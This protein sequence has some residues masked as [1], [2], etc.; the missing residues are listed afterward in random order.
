MQT[1]AENESELL[2]K[3]LIVEYDELLNSKTQDGLAMSPVFNILPSK[4]DYPDYYVLIKNPISFNTLKKRLTQYTDVQQFINDA[5]QIP[6]NAKMYNAK[7]S[8]I[9][10]YAV[11]L[12]NYITSSILI[13]L[14]QFYS[15]IEY[16]YLGALPDELSKQ[17]YA[18]PSTGQEMSMTDEN[19]VQKSLTPTPTQIPTPANNVNI[20]PQNMSQ[21]NNIKLNTPIVQQRIQETTNVNINGTSSPKTVTYQRTLPI[22]DNSSYSSL[23]PSQSSTP[24]PLYSRQSQPP[25]QNSQKQRTHV[26]RGRP[27][28][29]DLPYVQRIKNIL[30]MFRKEVDHAGEPLTL[31]FEKLPDKVKSPE[32][33]QLITNPISLDDIRKKVKT[34]KY[35]NFQTFQEEMKLMLSNYKIANSND[36]Q[37]AKRHI[38]L[39]KN[40]GRMVQFELSKPDEEYMPE[41]ELRYPLEEITVRGKNYYIGDWVMLDNPNDSS[42]PTVGQIFKLWS[43]PDGRKWLNACWYIRPEQTVHRVDR[44]FYKNEVVKTGQYRDHLVDEV[45][46]KCYVVHFTRFQR[47]DPAIKIDGP[48]FVCEFRYNENDKAFNKIR[49]WKA[50]LP[51]EIRGH[52]E[53]T[54][55]VNGRK[56]FKYPSPIKHMLPANAMPN[57]LTPQPTE[58]AING[59]PLIGAVYLRP[60]LLKDDLG[61]YSTSDDCPR[62]IIRPGDPQEDGKIDFEMGTITTNSTTTSNLPKTSHSNIKLSNL[63]QN[64]MINGMPAVQNTQ[65]PLI[66]NG[67]KNMM[68]RTSIPIKKIP[69]NNQQSIELSAKARQV[70]SLQNYQIN[71][72][73][74]TEYNLSSIVAN[75]TN[76]AAKNSV[77][78]VM[79]DTPGAYVLPVSLS[80]NVDI[81]QRSDIENQTKRYGKENVI[82]SKKNKGEILWFRGPSV[83]INERMIINGTDNFTVP[84]NRWV[85]K[86]KLDYEEIEEP[87]D[88]GEGEIDSDDDGVA[89][90][91]DDVTLPNMEVI[92]LKASASYIAYKLHSS[93]SI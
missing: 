10:K 88:E 73:R 35:K 1:M 65:F 48:L 78:Q 68:N 62:Y 13:R 67:S 38:L 81:L 64:K 79:V 30:K 39:E 85:K 69:V 6:W 40:F 89:E 20:T 55:P 52:D 5:A 76:K 34:R 42:K 11:D 4:R 59:P 2:L 9:Y 29:I 19:R 17:T 45:V 23:Q 53:V 26:K 91:N 93:M 8:M 50:C 41:G 54:I 61:E 90:P 22:D 75:L 63:K 71:S 47:G 33:Y 46:G 60:K 57:D 49:T 87:I 56:F 66:I 18:T 86:R 7:G 37:N 92:G 32:Y 84:L 83:H 15:H 77:G 72:K 21:V 58:G 82:K 51:E 25:V 24:Q 3:R 70:Q 16:P 44:L 74:T 14:K 12:E 27:P 43:T 80:K 36:P 31:T 28:V